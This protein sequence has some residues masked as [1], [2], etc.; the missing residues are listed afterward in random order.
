LN[1]RERTNKKNW[2]IFKKI[3]FSFLFFSI[4]PLFVF[5]IITALLFQDSNEQMLNDTRLLVD[6]NI[7]KNLLI[8]AKQIS[9]K[10][11]SFLRNR[12]FELL[13]IS[14]SEITSNSL[15]QFAQSKSIQIWIR[16]NQIN[17]SIGVWKFVPL[18]KEVEFIDNLGNQKIKIL[19]GKLIPDL[20]KSNIKNPKNTTYLSENYFE[21]SKDV[22]EGEVFVSHLNGFF[23]SREEFLLDPNIQYNGVIRFATPVFK[24]DKREGTLVLGLDHKH[25][26]EFT[27]HILPNSPEETLYPNYDSGDYAFMFDDKGW[28]I[29]HPKIWDIR[30]VDGNGKLIDAYSENTSQ[31]N[32]ERGFIPFNLDSSAFIHPNYPVVLQEVRRHKSGKVITTN[33]G[34]IKKIMVYSPIL[35]NKG[36]YSKHGIFGGITVGIESQNFQST[37]TE[38]D[39]MIRTTFEKYFNN[40]AYVILGSIIFSFIIS[41]FFS[42]NLTKPIIKLTHFAQNLADGKLDNRIELKRK[43]EIAHLSN[44]FNRMANELEKGRNELL[45]SNVELQNSQTHI[46]NYAFDLEYQLNILKSIQSISNT[47]GLTYDLNTV[48]KTILKTSIENINFDRTILYLLDEKNEHLEYREGSGFSKE[49]IDEAK[50]LKVLIDNPASIESY[51]LQSG[52]ILFVDNYSEYNSKT[53]R[54]LYTASFKESNS[55]L[56]IP[57]FVQDKIIGIFGADKLKNK[58]SENE[59]SSFQILANQASR[60]IENSKLYSE[61]I[62]QRNFVNDIISNMMN[63]VISTNGSGIIT[64][65]NKSAREVLELPTGNLVGLNIWDLLSQEKKFKDAI[66]VNMNARGVYKAYEKELIL[67]KKKKFINM[68]ASRV[69]HNNIHTSSI[70]IVE[71]VS[72]KKM[73]DE[74]LKKIDRLASLGRFAA[75]IAHEIRNPLTGLSLFLDNLHDRI[76][77]IDPA[78]SSLIS[79]ALNEIERLD[80]LVNEIL[81]YSVPTKKRIQ[82]ANINNIIDGILLLL[83]QQ[84]KKWNIVVTENFEE[85]IPDFA[86]DAERI[87]QAILNII[88]NSIHFM[89]NGGNLIIET[90]HLTRKES[91][92]SVLIKITDTGKGFAENE[93]ENIFDPFY[94]GRQEGTGL[95]LA[96]T[97]SIVSEHNGTIIAN[98]S[99]KHGA[100]F[101]IIIPIER[102][103]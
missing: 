75:G 79:N 103:T 28:I 48:L 85:S 35:Y 57:L 89:P 72:D 70:I 100:E 20:Q 18:Y 68:N 64:S 12:E 50:N 30:G 21:Y 83:N 33:V 36:V 80:N 60:V 34:G 8:Q 63:G 99:K 45:N 44:S 96:I 31:I 98:N 22:K 59:I 65:I 92:N 42:R 29:T 4:L 16:S 6:R 90:K 47:I 61:I 76:S 51:V 81:D 71:D 27:Q 23:V 91:S 25:L 97:H 58:I 94:S 7:E 46:Q 32:K 77:I 19:D 78:N 40:I 54:V 17:D 14:K 3:L 11:E 10:V 95:G 74:E 82:N 66:L 26:S 73:L 13:E 84:L 38:I 102:E 62:S 88:L 2:G 52:K 87:K 41:F 9:R 24:N 86:F 49:E 101:K 67:N 53:D 93:I 69:Y 55:F 39:K 37:S 15:L 43:D 56:F 5:A 1:R